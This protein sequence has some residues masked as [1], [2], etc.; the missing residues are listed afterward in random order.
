MK[1]PLTSLDY[2]S[3]TP[4]S[5]AQDLT[6]TVLPASAGSSWSDYTAQ[7]MKLDRDG[8]LRIRN[9]AFNA[10]KPNTDTSLPGFEA[11]EPEDLP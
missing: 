3:D 11:N 2:N 8:L 5:T 4:I 9:Q 10:A 1:D 6:T 7:H